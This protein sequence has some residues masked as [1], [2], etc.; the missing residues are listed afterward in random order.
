MIRRSHLRVSTGATSRCRGHSGAARCDPPGRPAP[1]CGVLTSSRA[2]LPRTFPD[3]TGRGRDTSGRPGVHQEPPAGPPSG[4]AGP[5]HQHVEPTTDHL[6]PG[7]GPEPSDGWFRFRGSFRSDC[8]SRGGRHERRGGSRE[9]GAERNRRG[10]TENGRPGPGCCF[11]GKGS[12]RWIE[13]IQILHRNFK[14]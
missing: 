5:W 13:S 3:R 8:L 14:G 2:A 9:N 4:P 10:F 7:P 6:V 1:S 12:R 11:G